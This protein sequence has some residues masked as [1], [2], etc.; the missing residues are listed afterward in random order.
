MARRLR[1]AD[2]APRHFPFRPRGVASG[3]DGDHEESSWPAGAGSAWCSVV[4]RDA[5]RGPLTSPLRIASRRDGPALHLDG[6][7]GSPLARLADNA[8]GGL[9]PQALLPPPREILPFA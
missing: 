6:Y 4:P 7:D 9:P 2:A 5:A 1:R 8:L 3:D